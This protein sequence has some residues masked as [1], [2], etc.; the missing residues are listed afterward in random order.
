MSR[1]ASAVKAV[2]LSGPYGLIGS[3][4]PEFCREHSQRGVVDV[5]HERCHQRGCPR[6][7]SFSVEGSKKP[8]Y[9]SEHS[10][11]GMLDVTRQN[12]SQRD[13]TKLPSFGE[14]G[15]KKQEYCRDRH[16][17]YR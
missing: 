8:R 17:G 11:E 4:K 7:P 9:C 15:S 12:C 16:G 6:R 14:R 5:K 3:K 10:R 13:C 2:V 1:A